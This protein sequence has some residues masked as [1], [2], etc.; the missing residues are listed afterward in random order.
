MTFKGP[1]PR[2]IWPTAKYLSHE[3]K[4]TT[5][6]YLRAQSSPAMLTVCDV[7][8]APKPV[9]W[10]WIDDAI[11]DLEQRNPTWAQQDSATVRVPGEQI[12]QSTTESIETAVMARHAN[13]KINRAL[14]GLV[15]TPIG[16]PPDTAPQSA[17][18]ERAEVPLP[19]AGC[20]A[21]EQ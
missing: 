17:L 16:L 11:Q 15:R 20:L 4:V 3:L 9:Y 13:D 8:K 1:R 14:S 5:L 21:A 18:D 10:V 6:N 12:F 2:T 19:V 7:G